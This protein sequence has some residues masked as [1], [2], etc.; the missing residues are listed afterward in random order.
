MHRNIFSPKVP[1]VD[2]DNLSLFFKSAARVT[3]IITLVLIPLW[4]V[5]WLTLPLGLVKTALVI[6]GL[7][8]V[9]MFST[10]SFLRSGKINLYFPLPLIFFW[11][12]VTSTIVSSLLSRDIFDSFFGNDLGVFSVSFTVL[13]ATLM[14]ACLLLIKNRRAISRLLFFALLAVF[15]V[16]LFTISRF[17]F[18]VDL[19]NFNV[20]VSNTDTIIGSLNDLAI[21]AGLVLL[22]TLAGINRAP[23]NFL[24]RSLSL[25]IV[26][27][28]LAILAVVNF[29]F[30]WLIICTLS[31]V[32]FFYLI[33]HDTW[34]AKREEDEV[35][36]VSSFTIGIVSLIF[37]TSGSFILGGDYLGARL[38]NL[39][40]ISYLEVRPSFTATA[41]I[42]SAVYKENILIGGGA[43]RFED[44]WRQ[45]KS[46]F[47]NETA[48]WQTDFNTGNS[49][50]FTTIIN[51]GVLGIITF[52]GFI[53]SLLY[54]A[55][56]IIFLY[57]TS[58][59]GWHT[60]GLIV[61]SASLYLWA[62]TFWYTPN[63]TI[64]LLLAM[65]TGLT[66]AV[67]Q[68]IFVPRPLNIDV[69]ISRPKGFALMAFSMVILILS[70]MTF[71]T[72]TKYMS[73][74]THLASSLTT[75]A[76][77]ADVKVYDEALATA[78]SKIQ[79]QDSYL[80]ARAK[81]RLA[82]L[83]RLIALTEP[84]DEDGINFENTLV[85]GVRLTEQAIAL[86]TTNPANYALL[87]NF[88]GLLD[89]KQYEGVAK[90]RGDAFAVARKYDP[91]NPKYDLAEAEIASRF[92][93]NDKARA[94]LA[95]A[96]DLK[97]DYTEALFLLAKLD[98]QSGN[99]TSAIAT[100]RSIIKI[101]PNNPARQF[102][103]G[104]LL[105]AN[106]NPL[107]AITAFENAITLDQQYA[108]ARYLLAL[109]YLDLNRPNDALAQLKIVEATNQ[110]NQLLQDLISRIEKGDYSTPNIGDI[111]PVSDQQEKSG[112]DNQTVVDNLPET[113][114]VAPV[115]LI[116]KTTKQES[117]TTVE[118]STSTTTD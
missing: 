23:A 90:K 56:R 94:K 106:A 88:Y 87:G 35:S 77:N 31:L 39:T 30:L 89:D 48:F 34:L 117:F 98:I 95:S 53:F 38:S 105:L 60:I 41:Q 81:L 99:A 62:V 10:L 59:K 3:L 58:D 18:G 115:N 57:Q 50:A 82:E 33:A 84:T 75:Y 21:Y 85:E 72:F 25:L 78:A 52:F 40:G 6:S 91:Q 22:I 19:L 96:L 46:P 8:L 114:L 12:F 107:E 55:Y 112:T 69:T 45:F 26:L 74:Q 67:G 14:T 79:G 11:L 93:D 70:S 104:L 109:T 51:T 92:G 43:N 113:N 83:G 15:G 66:L 28:S 9:I 17:F 86:D 102:Q 116:P 80:T 1:G 7:F 97:K 103:L 111:N 76:K 61:V 5:P 65:F 49:Y 71:V 73:A 54:I 36:S 63:Q 20:F 24:V 100:T 37:I 2:S 68:T 101:E 47:I 4:F 108:N 42:A 44:A 110:D 13:L 27:V 29:S 64:M 118:N 32:T 16:Y